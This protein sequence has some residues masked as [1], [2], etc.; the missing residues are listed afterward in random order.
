MTGKSILVLGG[1]GK[2]GGRIVRRLQDRGLPV[3]VGSR[4]AEPPFDWDNPA[5]WA[6]V[7]FDVDALYIAYQPDLAVPGAPETVR[8]LGEMAAA[9]GVRRVV[10]LSGRGEIEAQEAE[11]LLAQVCPQRTVI[12]SS[13]FAQNFTEG[14]FA[15][16]IAAGQLVLPVGQVPEPFIDIEDIADL[17][18]AALTEDGHAGEIYEVTGARSLTFAEAV[19]EIAAAAGRPIDYIQVTPEEYAAAAREHGLPEDL[20]EFL[21]YLFTTVLDGRNAAPSDGI[22]RGLGRAPRDFADYVRDAT[23]ATR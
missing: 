21:L 4:S 15:E 17:A 18:V 19:A 10:L 22:A 3:R 8:A 2:T 7:L 16:E 9:A 23:W 6:P 14:P 13:F 12:R 5:G 11:E 1:T 20:I